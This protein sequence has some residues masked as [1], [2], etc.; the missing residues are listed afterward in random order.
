[1]TTHT[2]ANEKHM[3]FNRK[4][5]PRKHSRV[6]LFSC[7]VNSCRS[8]DQLMESNRYLFLAA[9]IFNAATSCVHHLIYF[10]P[11]LLEKKP[12]AI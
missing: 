10:D 12:G 11:I 1:M 8:V 3:L 5:V 7:P 4:K 6:D 2:T 9:V